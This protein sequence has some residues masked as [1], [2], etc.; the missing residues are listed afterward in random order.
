ML[1]GPPAGSLTTWPVAPASRVSAA[2]PAPSRPRGPAPPPR[3]AGGGAPGGPPAKPPPPLPAHGRHRDPPRDEPGGEFL[4][5]RASELA[6]H[7]LTAL[8]D[9]PAGRE[10]PFRGRD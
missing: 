1:K 10:Q 7:L 8:R 3:P 4:H 2:W 5:D 6:P 9:G